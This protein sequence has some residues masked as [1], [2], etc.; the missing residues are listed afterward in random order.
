M[1]PPLLEIRGLRAELATR[2]GPLNMLDDV[3]FTL[4]RGRV[5]G[6]VGESGSGK[7]ATAFAIM[8]LLD[9]PTRVVGGS[10]RFAGRDLLGLK[11]AE[12]RR[13]RGN[14]IAMIFQD[15]MMTLNPVLTIGAQI[16]ETVLAH[17]P[18]GRAEARRRARDVL[19][20]V[21]VPGPEERLACHP[22][23]LSGGLRQRV[24]I[25]IALLHE[26][27]LIIADEPTT[28]LDATIQAQILREIRDLVAEHRTAV[29]WITH[30]LSVAEDLADEIA[31]M[32]AGRVVETGPEAALLRQPAHPY[33]VG[34]IASQ[35]QGRRGSRLTPIPGLPPTLASRPSGCAF[36]P[37]CALSVPDCAADP[38]WLNRDGG[39]AARCV[40]PGRAVA[41]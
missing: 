11:D 16:V 18:V 40:H 29:L 27:D 25:A 39:G 36:R 35:P 20:R 21:G 38:P 14:R 26:P 8:G 1:N 9:P 34:L 7:S 4:D 31:V 13:L 41:A 2:N 3:S 32:Y 15:P 37:R 30:D 22:H 24:A 28:A 6:L 23:Q 12:M 10:I 33:T 17:A 5:L 19:G